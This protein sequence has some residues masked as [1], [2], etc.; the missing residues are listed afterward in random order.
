MTSEEKPAVTEAKPSGSIR[1][2]SALV[3]LLLYGLLLWRCHQTAPGLE[4]L[5][6]SFSSFKAE[7][8]ADAAGVLKAHEYVTRL[9]GSELGIFPAIVFLTVVAM[10]LTACVLIHSKSLFKTRLIVLVVAL[11]ACTVYFGQ[12]SA[13]AL[14][15]VA[16]EFDLKSLPKVSQQTTYVEALRDSGCPYNER[17]DAAR[18][19]LL[20]G[21]LKYA[22]PAHDLSKSRDGLVAF[23]VEEK[24]AAQ[25]RLSAADAL[26]VIE[27]YENP[28]A[29][30]E[31]VEAMDRTYLAILEDP[32]VRS[33]SSARFF[34]GRIASSDQEALRRAIRSRHSSEG[35]DAG[36]TAYPPAL[37]HL[38]AAPV[39]AKAPFN[40][41]EAEQHQQ[42]WAKFLNMPVERSNHQGMK[43]RLIPPGEFRMGADDAAVPVHD[44]R[45]SQ[46]YYLGVTEVKVSQFR[47]LMN[48]SSNNP[49]AS[50]RPLEQ[51]LNYAA[52]E[53]TWQDA[54]DFCKKL[55]TI[56][57]AAGLINDRSEYR[58]PTEAEWEFACRAGTV[59]QYNFGDEFDISLAIHDTGRPVNFDRPA[60]PNPFGLHNLHGN[61][62]EW[63]RDFYGAYQA[64]EARDP[65]GPQT[66]TARVYRGGGYDTDR[67]GCRSAFR[68]RLDPSFKDHGIGFRVCLTV[69]SEPAKKP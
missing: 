22:E 6:Q 15:K 39:V 61:V 65:Q 49:S 45:L 24:S 21:Y 1:M 37:A 7:F 46:P 2:A 4:R 12:L 53:V 10:A 9:S 56:E 31:A 67:W 43:F 32:D 19:L 44:V 25:L 33:R 68:Y 26:Y 47:N 60:P 38:G 11:L 55:T 36:V 41:S 66:G 20:L 59:T 64:G 57:R 13:R 23:L 52:T 50:G 28:N 62:A 27:I 8:P 17:L 16:E 58:L 29:S 63:C 5:R 54:V 69:S 14:E 34:L 35:K 30:S 48:R 3:V 40:R 42:V 18:A 51:E